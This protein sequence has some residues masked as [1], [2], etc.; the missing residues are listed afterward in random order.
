MTNEQLSA[1]LEAAA[2]EK[3]GDWNVLPG[4]RTLTLHVEK[5]GV[6]LNVSKVTRVRVQGELVFAQNMR[7]ELTVLFLGD[8][9]AGAVDGAAKA[10]RKAGFR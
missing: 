7:E 9:F 5:G 6:G 2:V 10:V 4:E 3:D 1:L 8:V